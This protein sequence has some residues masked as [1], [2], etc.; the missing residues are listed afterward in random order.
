MKAELAIWQMSINGILW[1]NRAF[2]TNL[3]SSFSLIADVTAADITDGAER[4]SAYTTTRGSDG[5]G[6]V[7]AKLIWTKQ[8]K[9]W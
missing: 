5:A 3:I 7:K 4:A 1:K 2:Q 6:V 9:N 8:M